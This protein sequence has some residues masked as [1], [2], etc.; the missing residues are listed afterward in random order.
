MQACDHE[1]GARRAAQTGQWTAA[2]RAHVAQCA[3][4]SDE[5]L[6]TGVLGTWAAQGVTEPLPDSSRVWWAAQ[7]AARHAA[8]EQAMRPIRLVERAAGVVVAGLALAG[9]RWAPDLDS[10]SPLLR[11]PSLA[12]DALRLLLSGTFVVVAAFFLFSLMVAALSRA[13]Y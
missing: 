8:A 3:G 5:A 13:E 12:A 1:P 6:V 11:I 4:C 9:M 10:F 2:L 7:V